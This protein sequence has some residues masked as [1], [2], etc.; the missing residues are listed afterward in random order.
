MPAHSITRSVVHQ[1]LVALSASQTST[2]TR[3]VSPALASAMQHIESTFDPRESR[4]FERNWNRLHGSVANDL[5]G[6]YDDNSDK[7]PTNA[8]YEAGELL[9][10]INALP[11]FTQ[12]YD[13]GRGLATGVGRLDQLATPAHHE[14]LMQ[15]LA[16]R[17]DNSPLDRDGNPLI[18]HTFGR[19]ALNEFG[20]NPPARRPGSHKAAPGTSGAA[21]DLNQ[22]LAITDY[23]HPDTG[24]FNVVISAGRMAQY[25]QKR[26]KQ[27][28]SPLYIPFTSGLD[29]LARDPRFIVS[30]QTL[31][32]ALNLNANKWATEAVWEQ[33]WK[34]RFQNGQDSYNFGHPISATRS[35]VKTYA[36]RIGYD[37]IGKFTGF[38]G[39]DVDCF[40][41]GEIIISER[42]TLSAKITG[43]SNEEV[44]LGDGSIKDVGTIGFKRGNEN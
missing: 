25:G 13:I 40:N 21:L 44:V 8:K 4:S 43:F 9:R 32:K 2:A 22:L 6:L 38:T 19:D 29:T 7:F 16:S 10:F 15:E 39:V 23:T 28:I 1:T 20:I 17:I 30:G 18:V 35:V 42:Q 3:H 11:N 24:T 12:N 14:F 41:P 34:A 36:D 37:H 31:Y 33:D 27:A 26:F 5:Q